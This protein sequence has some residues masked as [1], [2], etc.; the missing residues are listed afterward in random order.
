[1]VILDMLM[2]PGMNG[3]ET[4]RRISEFLPHQKAIIASG[5]SDGINVKLAQSLGAGAYVKKP[6]T[7]DELAV[8]VRR[9]LSR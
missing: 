5:F 4:Y 1:M 2:E 3:Y 7:L 6:Y 9:E 8:A